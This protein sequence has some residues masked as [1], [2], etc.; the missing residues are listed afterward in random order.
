MI[1]MDLDEELDVIGSED[2]PRTLVILQILADVGQTGIIA[3]DIAYQFTLPLVVQRRNSIVNQILIRF[4]KRGYAYRVKEASPRYK[5]VPTYR[6]FITSA[7]R[8]YLKN[9]G[10][11]GYKAV[12]KYEAAERDKR[13]QQLITTRQLLSQATPA[14][15]KQLPPG[16]SKAR[17]DL[18]KKLRE[19]GM[20]IDETGQL[21]NITRQRVSQIIHGIGVGQCR[22]HICV[23]KEYN[24]GKHRQKP[25]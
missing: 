17:N 1:D 6:W 19:Q 15:I 22:C 10:W 7:G 18:M 8:D 16:C 14:L 4:G 23:V 9:D 21:F 3:P 24:H 12:I 25:S 2:R 20:T 5:N 13:R 11:E